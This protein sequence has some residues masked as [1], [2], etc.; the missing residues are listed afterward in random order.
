MRQEVPQ[1]PTCQQHVL[2]Q[3]S[4]DTASAMWHPT[5]CQSIG[6]QQRHVALCSSDVAMGHKHQGLNAYTHVRTHSGKTASTLQEGEGRRGRR[7]SQ[8]V[9][10]GRSRYVRERV[11]SD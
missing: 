5:Q 10:G 9:A 3:S 6:P 7:G 4:K 2:R 8:G 11:R 1:L